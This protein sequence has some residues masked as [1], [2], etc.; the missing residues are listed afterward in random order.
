V[1]SAGDIH[2]ETQRRVGGSLHLSVTPPPGPAAPHLFLPSLLYNSPSVALAVKPTWQKPKSSWAGSGGGGVP[3]PG[4]RG[5]VTRTVN[6]KPEGT[7]AGQVCG[8]RVGGRA[9][10]PC[11]L[12]LRRRRELQAA[13]GPL[14]PWSMD[15]V[16]SRLSPA[17]PGLC[18]AMCQR[19]SPRRVLQ[20]CG[21]FVLMHS[22]SPSVSLWPQQ[23]D[24]VNWHCGQAGSGEGEGAQASPRACVHG[25]RAL[26]SKTAPEPLL[27]SEVWT[28]L[29]ALLLCCQKDPRTLW[30]G[31][32]LEHKVWQP[33]HPWVPG[34]E[35]R[36]GHPTL[37]KLP[38]ALVGG[39]RDCCRVA[40]KAGIQDGQLPEREQ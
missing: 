5:G 35:Y 13:W 3:I 33:L 11:V 22:A 21:G 30:W 31:T 20:R 4:G 15:M 36:A 27:R 9:A 14:G 19:Q 26:V 17:D 8:C 34:R 25:G 40:T 24:G 37:H 6:Y 18:K 38:E 1:A 32:S 29:G 7:S 28:G 16:S 23:D 2:V 10:Q 39:L 12:M